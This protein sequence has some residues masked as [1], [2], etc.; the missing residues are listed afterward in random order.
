VVKESEGQKATIHRV[1]HEYKQGEL[2]SGGGGG[3]VK[4][5]RQAIAIALHEAGA[6]NRESPQKNEE[7]LRKTKQKERSGE[8]AEAEA[9]GKEAQD[10]T[11]RGGKSGKKRVKE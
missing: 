8:T 5:P 6:T 11:L 2:K 4:N 10:A 1:M 3:K 9:E 7:N